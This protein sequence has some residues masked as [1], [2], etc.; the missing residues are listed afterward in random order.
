MSK[1]KSQVCYRGKRK[2]VL[3]LAVVLYYLPTIT[4]FQVLHQ[5]CRHLKPEL[6]KFDVNSDKTGLVRLTGIVNG[7]CGLPEKNA[8]SEDTFQR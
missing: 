6:Y 4:W 2:Y 5:T 3:T 7:K 1:N 8:S